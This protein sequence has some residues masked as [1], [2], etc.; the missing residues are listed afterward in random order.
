MSRQFNRRVPVQAQQKP[1]CKVCRDAGKC[2]EVYTSHNVRDRDG[3]TICITLLNQEC[4]FCFQTGHTVK[5]C[6]VLKEREETKEKYAKGCARLERVKL[7]E[8]KKKPAPALCKAST[9]GGFAALAVDSDSDEGSPR[10]EQKVAEA[11]ADGKAY[12]D[13]VEVGLTMEFPGF[14]RFCRANGTSIAAMALSSEMNDHPSPK[15]QEEEFPALSSNVTLRPHQQHFATAEGESFAA[16]LQKPKP[17][18]KP[19]VQQKKVAVVSQR[20]AWS[21]DEESTPAVA[22]VAPVQSKPLYKGGLNWA[23]CVSSDDEDDEPYFSD[24]DSYRNR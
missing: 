24:G 1:F 4:R 3:N 6:P 14:S 9:G 7:H 8:E 22:A 23:D 13:R 5:F 2:E 12:F 20:D 21:D 15:T 11:Y 10:K 19:A 16:T 17:Q 18:P